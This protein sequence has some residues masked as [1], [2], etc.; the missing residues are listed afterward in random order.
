MSNHHHAAL[1]VLIDDDDMGEFITL[2]E[3]EL[4]NDGLTETSEACDDDVIEPHGA[5]E[6]FFEITSDA[7]HACH[8]V[9]IE[10]NAV[11]A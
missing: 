3:P 5:R 10:N 9:A 8:I 7:G 2:G 6:L 4:F 1:G 11:T